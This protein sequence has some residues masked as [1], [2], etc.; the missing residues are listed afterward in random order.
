[1]SKSLEEREK[2][3][4]ERSFAIDQAVSAADRI[5]MDFSDGSTEE[6]DWLTSEVANKFNV[7][8]NI[9]LSAKLSKKDYE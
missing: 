4:R 3:E 8:V 2:R 1:M 7:K 9:A 5:I 6:T